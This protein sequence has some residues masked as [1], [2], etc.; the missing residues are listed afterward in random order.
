[1]LV[2]IVCIG[3]DMLATRCK[4]DQCYGGPPE[5]NQ[6]PQWF[7]KIEI[8]ISSIVIATVIF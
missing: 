8:N 3:F 4:F 1:M 7:L 6:K 5:N 2:D